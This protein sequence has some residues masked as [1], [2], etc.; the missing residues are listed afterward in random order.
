MYFVLY[1]GGY[2]GVHPGVHQQDTAYTHN[3][4]YMARVV[5]YCTTAVFTDT[6]QA[7]LSKVPYT[8]P[9]FFGGRRDTKKT[10]KHAARR[11]KQVGPELTRHGI[12]T[13]R[14]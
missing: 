6:A 14:K 12:S 8:S 1:K 13:A 5:L 3:W 11:N 7:A 10:L 2:G 9:K 4:Y